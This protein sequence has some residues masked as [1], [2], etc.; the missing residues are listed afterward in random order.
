VL[1]LQLLSTP[2]LLNVLRSPVLGDL[3]GSGI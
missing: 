3:L 1:Q 2:N